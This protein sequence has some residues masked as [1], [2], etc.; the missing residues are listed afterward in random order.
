MHLE[1]EII[2]TNVVLDSN[3]RHIGLKPNSVN[4]LFRRKDQ[5]P[6]KNPHHLSDLFLSVVTFNNY[7]YYCWWYFHG[8]WVGRITTALLLEIE[9]NITAVSLSSLILPQCYCQLLITTI[10]ISCLTV[11]Y[12]LLTLHAVH[13]TTLQQCHCRVQDYTINIGFE[14]ITTV[15]FNITT[16]LPSGFTLQQCYLGFNI[17]TNVTLIFYITTVLPWF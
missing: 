12:L 6:E 7:F 9:T 4:G 15:W 1:N 16:M 13:F 14:V 3:W 11:F 8:G 2:E 17:T 5:T 10:L